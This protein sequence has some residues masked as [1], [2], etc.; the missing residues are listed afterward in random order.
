MWPFVSR[1][2]MKNSGLLVGSSDY[3]SHILPAVDDG[4]KTID[5]A[6]AILECFEQQGI[7]ALWLT[8]HVMED[9]PNTTERLRL[10]FA[11]LKAEYRGSVKLNLAAEYMLDNLFDARLA[12][13]DLLPLGEQGNHILVETSFFN[14]P[15][16]LYDTI[17]RIKS[18]GYYPL[19]AHPERYLYMH[20]KDYKTLKTTGV[21]FQLNWA[22]LAGYYGRGVQ[23]KAE[24]LVEKS[25]YD[26]AGSDTH[27]L[28]LRHWEMKIDASVVKKIKASSILVRCREGNL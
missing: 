9:I 24:W 8:P 25:M 16:C 7:A 27:S 14:P 23:K 28:A 10:R 4:V 13:N 12:D 6:L 21:K 22:S 20:E 11:Q 1:Q 15:M 18:K 17:A 26:V 3:H 5:E 2:T 19:L